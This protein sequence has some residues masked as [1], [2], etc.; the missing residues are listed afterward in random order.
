LSIGELKPF[1]RDT[2]ELKASLRVLLNIE[3]VFTL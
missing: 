3:E 1:G 2:S